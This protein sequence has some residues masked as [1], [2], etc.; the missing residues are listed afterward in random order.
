MQLQFALEGPSC[1]W[2]INGGSSPD[3]MRFFN[4]GNACLLTSCI[5]IRYILGTHFPIPATDRP[6]L[7]IWGF[8]HC[9]S[10]LLFPSC[11]LRLLLTEQDTTGLCFSRTNNNHIIISCFFFTYTTLHH[12]YIIISM[13]IPGSTLHRP[14]ITVGTSNLGSW[15]SHIDHIYVF[16]P[17]STFH[18]PHPT[19]IPSSRSQEMFPMP[20]P[21]PRELPKTLPALDPLGE[22][23]EPGEGG[24]VARPD[25][26]G[27]G[28]GMR[29][30]NTTGQWNEAKL[31]N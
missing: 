27:M 1:K 7:H 23:A 30:G 14:Y 21:M 13:R 8:F 6:L 26:P 4:A 17:K 15:N 25:P 5:G 2:T 19:P 24:P 3:M 16:F 9:C 31:G 29:Y 11:P 20:D 10:I 22:E 12:S 18:L 28:M